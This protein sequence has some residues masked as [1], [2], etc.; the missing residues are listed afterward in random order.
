MNEILILTSARKAVFARLSFLGRHFCD[1]DVNE[2]VS[3]TVERF[4]TRGSYDASK[5]SVQTYVSRIARNVVYDFVKASDRSRDL[6]TRLDAILDKSWDEDMPLNADPVWTLCFGDD[7]EADSFLLS[8][9]R[10]ARLERAKNKLSLRFREYFD[11]CSQGY[12]Y[13]E[14]AGLTGSTVSNV[15]VVMHR[16]RK[17]FLTLYEEVA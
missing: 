14:I 11:L 6:F 3:S 12:S 15:S 7:C 2:M 13:E 9:E 8:E 10:K 5:A 4:Y 1:D 17:Q 16:M